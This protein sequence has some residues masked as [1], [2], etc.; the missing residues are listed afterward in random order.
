[1]VTHIAQEY[2]HPSVELLDLIQE[3]NIG[4][5]EAVDR[6][7]PELGYQFS[8]FAVWWIRKMILLYLGKDEDKVSLDLPIL[9]EAGEILRLGDT[10]ID[11]ENTLGGQSCEKQGVRLEHE[12]SMQQ[13]RER[14]AKLP[15]REKEVLMMLYG[16]G[17]KRA[18]TLQ[19][20]A[21]L[22]D[23]TPERVGQ[24][25]DKALGRLK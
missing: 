1:L 5:I 10:I 15:M 3:G 18:L 9:G 4:L 22:L 16:I 7:D 23:I 25:R 12:Q 24:I 13:M 6:F 21:K 2:Y 11:E 20:I 14:M 8:T 17:L 19:E